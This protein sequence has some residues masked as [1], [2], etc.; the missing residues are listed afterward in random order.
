MI[1]MQPS[2]LTIGMPK[3]ASHAHNYYVCYTVFVRSFIILFSFL[4]FFKSVTMTVSRVLQF[5]QSYLK[6]EYLSMKK[7]LIQS[8]M[9]NSF[10]VLKIKHLHSNYLFF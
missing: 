5:L 3:Q 9:L 1:M 4:C 8:W 10:K 7:T 6:N 2:W